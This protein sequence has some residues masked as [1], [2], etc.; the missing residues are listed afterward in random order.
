M[1][2]VNC[3]YF[4]YLLT[5][6]NEWKHQFIFCSNKSWPVGG[7]IDHNLSRHQSKLRFCMGTPCSVSN[8]PTRSSKKDADQLYRIKLV[9]NWTVPCW[10]EC[11]VD[12]GILC[13]NSHPS[14]RWRL[15]L[16]GTERLSYHIKYVAEQS[17]A[18][19]LSDGASAVA[20]RSVQLG[21]AELDI[22]GK[23]SVSIYPSMCWDVLHL[24]DMCSLLS[25]WGAHRLKSEIQHTTC[26][27]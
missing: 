15:S 17:Y 13:W 5:G 23:S 21:T 7:N 27:T 8:V 9:L 26:L 22:A 24:F 4:G 14:S 18:S 3:K 19:A 11:L 6:Q 2:S 25:A 1:Y 20:C 10:V 16:R 12:R